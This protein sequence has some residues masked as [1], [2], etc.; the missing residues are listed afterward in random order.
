MAKIDNNAKNPFTYGNI[1]DAEYCSEESE[2][3]SLFLWA[4]IKERVYPSIGLM[5]HCPNG[6]RRDLKTAVALKRSGVKA[7][8]PDIC[9]PVARG[10]YHGLYIELKVGRNKP[11]EKQCEYLD[12]LRREG[13]FAALCYGWRPASEIIENYL[14][15]TIS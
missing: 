10:K 6:G 3:E 11:T 4:A 1:G 8:V 7:G 13:F 12:A 15:G 5:Y 2:Q 14:K 9:L